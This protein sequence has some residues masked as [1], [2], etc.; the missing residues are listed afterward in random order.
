MRKKRE[1]GKR[2]GKD[3]RGGGEDF[4]PGGGIRG[5]VADTLC[6]RRQ[7]RIFLFHGSPANRTYG[8][9]LCGESWR[10]QRCTPSY[11]WAFYCMRNPICMCLICF[12]TIKAF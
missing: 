12:H 6:W 2:A 8:G 1:K 3:W 5:G 10:K 4:G 7:S 9:D 11:V